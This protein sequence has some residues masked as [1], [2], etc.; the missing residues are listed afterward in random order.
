MIEQQGFAAHDRA[1]RI[2]ERLAKCSHVEFNGVKWEV[3]VNF[4]KTKFPNNQASTVVL[5]NDEERIILYEADILERWCIKYGT[6][7][8]YQWSIPLGKKIEV[9]A[10]EHLKSEA[11][12]VNDS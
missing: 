12:D 9:A 10:V 8:F 1:K 3:S 5:T 4:P 7:H 2:M 6:L 11:S